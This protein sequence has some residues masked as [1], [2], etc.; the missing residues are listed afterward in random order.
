MEDEIVSLDFF[1]YL[2]AFRFIYKNLN[3]AINA[4]SFNQ[5]YTH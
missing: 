3:D 2:G 4:I 5:S 1:I